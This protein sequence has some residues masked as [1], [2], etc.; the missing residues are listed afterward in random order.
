MKSQT[1]ISEN[2][3]LFVV[4]EGD[5]HNPAI[6]FIHGFPDCHKTYNRQFE[7]LK[8]QFYLISFDLRGVGKS[9]APTQKHAYR[10]ERLLQDLN[11][12]VNQVLGPERAFHLFGHDW[13]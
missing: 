4:T 7:A 13:G 9:S 8:D 12:V 6:V 10:V 3:E 1:V 5:P 11:N 2:I